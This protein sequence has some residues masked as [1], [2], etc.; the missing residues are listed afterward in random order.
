[1]EFYLLIAGSRT[2]NNYKEMCSLCDFMLHNH[3]KAND[4]IHIVEGA[5]K[6]ADSLAKQYAIMRGY[7]LHEFPADWNKYGKSAGYKRNAIMHEF[8]SKYENRGCLCFWDGSS[9]GTQ[10]N[11]A[12]AH[13]AGTPLRVYNYA[14]KSW[15]KA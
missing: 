7:Q 2:Y 8:I 11:F 4:N 3:V 9:K 6:G 15:V 1:M 10:H 14:D 13:D 5:A 12:L